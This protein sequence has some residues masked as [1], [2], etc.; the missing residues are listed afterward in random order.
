MPQP[1]AAA[2]PERGDNVQLIAIS[3]G[4]AG[5]LVLRRSRVP[6]AMGRARS[7]RPERRLSGFSGVDVVIAFRTAPRVL[8]TSRRPGFQRVLA[9][10]PASSPRACVPAARQDERMFVATI[11]L[12]PRRADAAVPTGPLRRDARRAS[13]RGA[14]FEL[15]ALRDRWRGFFRQRVAPAFAHGASRRVADFAATRL[16]RSCCPYAS[17]QSAFARSAQ[18][19]AAMG[20]PRRPP[21]QPV[22]RLRTHSRRAESAASGENP[23]WA[24]RLRDRRGQPLA[25]RSRLCA[26]AAGSRRSCSGTMRRRWFGDDRSE[27]REIVEARTDR[28]RSCA[29]SRSASARVFA[30]LVRIASIL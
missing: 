2:P 23:R 1:A 18:E 25:L 10:V 17:R 6:R 24:T 8:R 13:E 22:L 7:I 9:G 5:A 4:C 14:A 15:P 28:S 19:Q 26:C 27:S 12:A 20:G 30:S 11:P 16:R 21:K 29:R 3:S